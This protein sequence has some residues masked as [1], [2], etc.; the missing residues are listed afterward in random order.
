M[1]FKYFD[2]ARCAT[3]TV[4]AGTVTLGAAIARYRTFAAA[5]AVEGDTFHYVI[6]DGT[7]WEIGLGTYSATG[8]T[9][10]RTT[11]LA[12]STGSKLSLSGAAM[13]ACDI[14]AEDL[15]PAGFGALPAMA[16][17]TAMLFVQTTPP[18]GWTKSV[19]HNDK[20]LRIVSGTAGSG[21]TV[22]FSTVFGR[23]AADN[24]TL[25]ATEF[26]AHTHD[27]SGT[28]GNASVSHSHT[29]NRPPSAQWGNSTMD[30]G[31]ADTV[32]GATSG[33][34]S[35]NHT[36]TFADTS[37]SIGSGGAHGHGLDMRVAYADAV[38][39]TKD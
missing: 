20:M 30:T 8:P 7:A 26:P 5:G 16:A 35:A 14:I 9:V 24:F 29:Y 10:A 38:I 31:L 6:E 1:G 22:A 17:G 37:D 34:Q 27:F 15:T 4:G 11:L 12:S 21:G 39:A 13:I 3:A 18:T 2:R 19:T 33:A 28:T 32:A 36:H 23:T 25:T